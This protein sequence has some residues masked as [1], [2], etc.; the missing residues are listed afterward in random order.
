LTGSLFQLA[1]GLVLMITFFSCRVIW[2]WY[3][4]YYFI[5]TNSFVLRAHILGDLYVARQTRPEDSPLWLTGIF[6]VSNLFLNSLN[7]YWFAKMVDSLRRRA[8]VREHMHE[9]ED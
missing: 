4:T 8:E 3:I 9:H 5:G 6:V 1:N 2:G 7:I